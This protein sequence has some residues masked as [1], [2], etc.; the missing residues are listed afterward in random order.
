MSRVS[1]LALLDSSATPQVLLDSSATP[2]ALLDSSATPQVLLD[3]SATP[4][5]LLD[6]RATP[7]VLLD[8]SAATQVLLDGSAATQAAPREP[9]VSAEE[10]PAVVHVHGRRN[11]DAEHGAPGSRGDKES[12]VARMRVI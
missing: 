3:S 2:Q 10:V 8:G 1:T 5:A 4:Q 12:V 11:E 9:R 7:Q 6:S